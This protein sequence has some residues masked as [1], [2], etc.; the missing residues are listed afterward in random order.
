M[1]VHFKVNKRQHKVVANNKQNEMLKE[2]QKRS[3]KDMVSII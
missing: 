3:Q 2:Q 1:Q